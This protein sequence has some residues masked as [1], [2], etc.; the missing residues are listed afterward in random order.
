MSVTQASIPIA[1]VISAGP[2]VMQLSRAQADIARWEKASFEL[3]SAG[4][5]FDSGGWLHFQ[6][7][8][9][10]LPSRFFFS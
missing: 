2:W 7:T 8:H 6:K 5:R 9:R 10:E 1:S 4:R 3:Q